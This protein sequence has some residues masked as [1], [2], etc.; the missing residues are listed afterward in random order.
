MAL[1]DKLNHIA[2]MLY[3]VQTASEVHIGSI[4]DAVAHVE[5]RYSEIDDR[6]TFILDRIAMREAKGEI[7]HPMF[8]RELIRVEEQMLEVASL[9]E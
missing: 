6:R 3:K 4:K 7:A 8:A 2:W 1:Q 5:M 9:L